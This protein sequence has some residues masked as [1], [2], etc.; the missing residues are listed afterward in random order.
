[1]VYSYSGKA[2]FYVNV[3]TSLITLISVG[4]GY[5][6]LVWGELRVG[7][8]LSKLMRIR[9]DVNFDDNK[10]ILD[11]EPNIYFELDY[12]AEIESLQD[13]SNSKIKR[14]FIEDFQY[15]ISLANPYL[16]DQFPAIWREKMIA[17]IK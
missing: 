1:M 3:P 8:T 15:N 5:T 16:N 13:V 9:D 10:I 6:G 7:D 14:I 17:S 12:L 11:N 4:D 2:E